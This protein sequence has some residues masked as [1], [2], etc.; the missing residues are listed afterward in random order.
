MR[1]HQPYRKM[2]LAPS[3]RFEMPLY[4]RKYV[5][6]GVCCKVFVN[7][8]ATLSVLGSQCFRIAATVEKKRSVT[9]R[10]GGDCKSSDVLN[11]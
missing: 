5:S 2:T 6:L 4:T 8:L 7:I 10:K 1:W 11:Q 9:F 3:I